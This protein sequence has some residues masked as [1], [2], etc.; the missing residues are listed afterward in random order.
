MTSYVPQKL[1]GFCGVL[2]VIW[3]ILWRTYSDLMDSVAYLQWFDG[4]CGVLT[5]IWWILWRTY[6]DLM[7]SVVYLQWFDGFCGVLERVALEL[8]QVRICWCWRWWRRWF[9][10]V[11]RF[12]WFG[13]TC[14]R[15]LLEKMTTL[16][17]EKLDDTIG[18]KLS[19][20]T[21][22]HE[23]E[24]YQFSQGVEAGCILTSLCVD[25]ERYEV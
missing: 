24:G 23:L 19:F 5:V 4:F 22:G 17:Q 2:T 7:D 18:W 25:I 20:A 9:G 6:S 11:R 13:S 14:S 10:S 3:W 15:V 21:F 12:R 8:L 16:L 1:A